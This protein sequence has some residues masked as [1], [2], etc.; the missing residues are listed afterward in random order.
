MTHTN[1]PILVK[2]CNMC[3]L[4]HRGNVPRNDF[5]TYYDYADYDLDDILDRDL[6]IGLAGPPPRWCPLRMSD[7]YIRRP[8]DN[9]DDGG[10]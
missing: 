2:G 3:P 9:L 8:N 6:A 10:Y 1:K 4:A 7:V 5:C